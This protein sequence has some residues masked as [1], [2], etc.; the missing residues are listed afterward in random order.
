MKTVTVVLATTIAVLLSGCGGNACD[1][2]DAAN[3]RFFGSSNQCSYMSGGTSVTVRTNQAS[4][5]S[6][7][8]ALAKC[9]SADLQVLDGFMKCVEAAPA[10]T[11]GNEKT[12]ADAYAACSLQLVTVS[13]TSIMSKLSTECAAGFQ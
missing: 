12:A 4:L 10:C 1:R 11:A 7:N 2:L 6:C 8:A 13:G 3:K 9:S 5:S